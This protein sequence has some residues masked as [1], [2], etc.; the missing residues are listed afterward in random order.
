M[1][2]DLLIIDVDASRASRLAVLADEM[3]EDPRCGLVLRGLDEPDGDGAVLITTWDADVVA[4][5]QVGLEAGGWPV[6]RL[7][8]AE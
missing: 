6:R 4:E 7:R 2:S 1:P 5:V 3:T 8:Q